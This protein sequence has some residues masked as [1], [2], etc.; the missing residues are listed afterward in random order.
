MAV[1]VDNTDLLD[2]LA[3][4]GNLPNEVICW[5]PGRSFTSGSFA[6]ICTHCHGSILE[7]GQVDRRQVMYANIGIVP[8]VLCKKAVQSV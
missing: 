1:E 7:V 4:A 3:H 6:K 5:F 8:G 2:M